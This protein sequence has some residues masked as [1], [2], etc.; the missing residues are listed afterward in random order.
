MVHTLRRRADRGV[1]ERRVGVGRFHF[2]LF[3]GLTPRD[4]DGAHLVDLRSA[5][6]HA[7]KLAGAALMRD[8]ERFIDAPEWRIEVTD[9]TGLLVFD[10]FLYATEAPTTLK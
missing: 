8:P 6:I 5:S 10:L 9:D 2:N 7:A 3:D 1:L 4:K